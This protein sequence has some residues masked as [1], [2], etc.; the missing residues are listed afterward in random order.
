MNIY[1]LVILF[2]I[3]AS[4]IV[5]M[6]LLVSEN[7]GISVLYHPV[8]NPEL[9]TFNFFVGVVL[10]YLLL[11]FF[12][13][14][15]SAFKF[16]EAKINSVY[17]KIILMVSALINVITLTAGIGKAGGDISAFGFLQNILP[18]S[19][20][21]IIYYASIRDKLSYDK[22]IIVIACI[23]IGLLKGWTG[24]I[25][26][27]V[28][29]EILYRYNS[30]AFTATDIFKLIIFFIFMLTLYYVLIPLKFYIRSGVFYFYSIQ[31]FSDYAF[32]RLSFFSLFNYLTEIKNELCIDIL[33]ERT[34]LFYIQ[35][36]LVGFLPKSIF[37]LNDYRML[38]N[39]FAVNYVSSD[40]VY[41]GF[42]ITLPGLFFLSWS[43]YND[44]LVLTFFLF[45]VFLIQKALMNYLSLNNA[46]DVLF[47]NLVFFMS[48]GS[49]KEISIFNYTILITL[50]LY[51]L[52]KKLIPT[53][54]TI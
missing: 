24:H 7:Y 4:S 27:I 17:I 23:F 14:I 11:Y 38:D 52:L 15:L 5:L 42:S 49:M 6:S 25:L 43:L 44:V 47:I 19:P 48:S 16:N 54:S 3:L 30:R 21:T 28:F 53:K 40:L 39:I 31:E 2:Y 51:V 9:L 12:F 18:L 32:S 29:Y 34:Y 10:A 37:N 35:E 22:L 36:Y 41:S 45:C 46:N 20:L 33:S 13:K 8:K 1:I 50:I 26:V